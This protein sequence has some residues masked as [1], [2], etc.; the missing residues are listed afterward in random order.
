M[1]RG[2]PGIDDAPKEVLDGEF[3]TS[4]IQWTTQPV[5]STSTS[6]SSAPR[7]W[8]TSQFGQAAPKSVREFANTLTKWQMQK[9][10]PL[11]IFDDAAEYYTGGANPLTF[12]LR[13]LE[14]TNDFDEDRDIARNSNAADRE[15]D[16]ESSE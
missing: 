8:A 14:L 16:S 6:T 15:S 7:S 5:P 4:F 2:L 3:W 1:L 10:L 11:S 13:V 9:E 12:A